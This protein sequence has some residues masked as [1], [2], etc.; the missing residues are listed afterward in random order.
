MMHENATPSGQVNMDS[1]TH[2]CDDLQVPRPATGE[3]P[4][5]NVRVSNSLWKAAQ[6]KAKAEGRTLTDV[7]V[8][9]LRRYVSTPPRDRRP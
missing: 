3:T 4:S 5:R 1:R 8:A 7:I 2:T 9:Y 6:A